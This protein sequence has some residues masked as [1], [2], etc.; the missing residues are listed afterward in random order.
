VLVLG[1]LPAGR[2]RRGDV[3]LYDEARFFTVTGEQLT[4]T[5]ASIAHRASELAAVHEE[6]VS[7]ADDSDHASTG[8]PSKQPQ[9]TVETDAPG[10]DLDDTEVLER[11][12]AAANGE[13]FQ[14]LWRGSTAGYPSQSEADMALCALLAF[15]TGG[16]AA[17][18]NRLFRDSGLLRPKWDEQHFADGATYG[19]RT[20]E[21]AIV[22]TDEYYSKGA[23]AA[24]Q[25]ISEQT[26]T[27]ESA[28]NAVASPAAVDGARHSTPATNHSLEQLR[29]RLA[30]LEAENDCLREAL[31]AERTADT[32]GTAEEEA[33]QPGGFFSRLL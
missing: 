7:A 23:T 27:E 1:A 25:P 6:Y 22:G 30:E 15:W 26:A 10:N 16:D 11:A 28:S 24:W 2:N 8:Q 3:E 17:Q 19:E 4:D 5:P 32:D 29:E 20:I 9:G 12:K 14:R 21:R 33:E 18:M 31:A 13:K